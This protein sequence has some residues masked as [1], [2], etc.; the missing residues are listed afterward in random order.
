MENFVNTTDKSYT[1]LNKELFE[2]WWLSNTGYI[3]KHNQSTQTYMH[4]IEFV[5]Y[6]AWCELA[7]WKGYRTDA[8]QHGRNLEKWFLALANLVH[9]LQV[10]SQKAG[11]ATQLQR[12][13][14]IVM[15]KLFLPWKSLGLP[16]P[17]E[18]LARGEPVAG[19]WT[20]LLRPLPGPGA[21]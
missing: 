6:F 10:T 18:P 15:L 19:L 8:R 11:A 21:R 12:P 13:L 16:G 2:L 7:R 5:F 1:T 9:A 4:F 20:V 3:W 17:A 14:P